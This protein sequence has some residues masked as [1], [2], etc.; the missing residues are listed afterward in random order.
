MLH[1]TPTGQLF[2]SVASRN[3]QID[4]SINGERVALMDIDWKMTETDKNGLNL[5]TPRVHVKAGPQHIAAAFIQ[6]F[7]GVVDDLVSPI[8]YTLADTEYGDNAGIT[9]LPH[10]RDFSI[11]GPY[12][13]TGVSDTPSRR[14]VFI[15]RPTSTADEIPCARKILSSLAGEAYRRTPNNEDVESLM[16][17]YG[18]APQGPRLRGRHQSGAAGAAGEPEVRVPLREHADAGQGRVRPIASA[19]SIWRRGCRSSSGTRCRTRSW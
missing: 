9:I 14:K 2:G 16:E 11:T 19:I 18:N 17:F 4:L 8:D 12:K 1:G 10:V 13:V 15:C 3:E 6:K 5:V 7:D